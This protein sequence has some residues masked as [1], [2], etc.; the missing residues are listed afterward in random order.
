MHMRLKHLGM[1]HLGH[2]A[3]D[4]DSRALLR[5][6]ALPQACL[7]LSLMPAGLTMSQ[8]DDVDT[9]LMAV[10]AVRVKARCLVEGEDPGAEILEQDFV[11]LNVWAVLTRL[12]H[13]SSGV[14]RPWVEPTVTGPSV[15]C[16]TQMLA[17][18][19]GVGHAL[20]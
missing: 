12:A 19:L 18:C 15:V 3:A 11:T 9:T 16:L 4:H 6:D 1:E 13:M 2:D 10:P 20:E 7:K 14:P 5:A 8:I 17:S